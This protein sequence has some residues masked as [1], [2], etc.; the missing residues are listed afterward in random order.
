MKD[1][2]VDSDINDGVS[3]YRRLSRFGRSMSNMVTIDSMTIRNELELI[4]T[5]SNLKNQS[6]PHFDLVGRIREA[7]DHGLN[8]SRSCLSLNML[9]RLLWG[10]QSNS[11]YTLNPGHIEYLISSFFMFLFRNSYTEFVY[12]YKIKESV[13]NG[14]KLENNVSVSLNEFIKKNRFGGPLILFCGIV[15]RHVANTV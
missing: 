4:L 8:S 5:I 14:F 13:F 2:K 1:Q 7:I 6:V 10:L 9:Q 15:T 3:L 11:Q 12:D